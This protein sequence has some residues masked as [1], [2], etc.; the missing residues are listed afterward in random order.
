MRRPSPALVIACIAL[1]C[2]LSTGALA[3]R[4]LLTGKDVKDASLTGKDIKDKSIKKV[5][6]AADARA[7]TGGSGATGA[8][9]PA[10]ATGP[11]GPRGTAGP[12][13]L[14]G[15]TGPSTGAASGDLTGSYPAPAIAAGAVTASKT[16]PRP[17]GE[18]TMSVDQ[19]FPASTSGPRISFDHVARDVGGVAVSPSND[20]LIAPIAGV[21]AVSANIC[22]ATSATGYRVLRLQTIHSNGG[23][24]SY[25]YHGASSVGANPSSQTCQTASAILPLEAGDRVSTYPYQNSGAGLVVYADGAGQATFAMAWIAPS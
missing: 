1:F 15:D 20:E 5:D 13:G 17:Y 9:G 12:Q 24:T 25:N 18:L 16:G 11:A 8:A 3:A 19:T 21:Y 6:L 2:S 10:G 4:T 22:W 14:K 23:L 7:V